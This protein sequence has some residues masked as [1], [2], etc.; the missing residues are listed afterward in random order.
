MC[1]KLSTMKRNRVERV[2]FLT[3]SFLPDARLVLV[4]KGSLVLDLNYVE[5]SGCCITVL[6]PFPLFSIVFYAHCFVFFHYTTCY[7]V[8]IG[9]NAFVRLPGSSIFV[10]IVTIVSLL[11]DGV[12]CYEQIRSHD[13]LQGCGLNCKH[14]SLRSFSTEQVDQLKNGRLFKIPR[15]KERRQVF[16]QLS[17]YHTM[18]NI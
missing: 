8:I 3:I 9:D 11:R 14:R 2:V 18:R 15:T 4:H 1:I 7:T 5:W 10:R 6:V 12:P 17:C 13:Y 16:V